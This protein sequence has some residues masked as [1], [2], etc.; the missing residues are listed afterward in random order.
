MSLS[1]E[2]QF[3][4]LVEANRGIIRKVTR[5]YAD[6]AEDQQDLQQEILYHAWRS[7]SSFRGQAK[8]STWL[9]RVSLNTALT[10]HK[11][12]NRHNRISLEE[13]SKYWDAS[14]C[15]PTDDSERLYLGIRQLGEAE[16]ALIMLYLDGY[17]NQ[18]IAQIAGITPNL[19]AVKL[20][21]IKQSLT[22]SLNP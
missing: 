19:V 18:E 7:F 14:E 16:R 2:Q 12:A 6:T 15:S 20:H 3:V 8:F 13:P 4:Q 10:F 21:R 1:E 22:K 5:M 17:S 11:R 9:Y